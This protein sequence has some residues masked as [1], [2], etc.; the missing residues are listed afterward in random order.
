MN[1]G[2]CAYREYKSSIIAI[3]LK[4][5][6]F[7]DWLTGNE[8]DV[9]LDTLTR[10][11]KQKVVPPQLI[12]RARARE[13]RAG[14]NSQRIQIMCIESR[15]RSMRGKSVGSGMLGMNGIVVRVRTRK[16]SGESEWRKVG[17][18]GTRRKVV[19]R[20][21]IVPKGRLLLCQSNSV[22]RHG[23]RGRSIAFVNEKV[24]QS[25]KGI[26]CI[27]RKRRCRVYLRG[28]RKGWVAER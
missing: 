25:Q 17:V 16:R 21:G 8:D 4:K 24:H 22:H 11:I 18:G 19:F 2:D 28:D 15:N 7:K 26:Q 6:R 13:G 9:R 20:E 1:G 27:Q 23:I 12:A 5:T 14:R 3:S 10:I